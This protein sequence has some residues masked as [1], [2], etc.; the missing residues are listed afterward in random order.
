MTDAPPSRAPDGELVRHLT[1]LFEGLEA[2]VLSELGGEIEWRNLRG[3]ETLFRRGDPG[4]AAYVVISGRLRAVIEAES[5]ERVLNEMGAGET[6]GEMALLAADARSATVYAVRDAQLA[7][8]SREAFERLTA[9]HPAALRRIAGFVVERL[10]RRSEP[11]GPPRVASVTLTLVAARPEVDLPAFAEAL[12]E[13]LGRIGRVQHLRRRDVDAGLGRAGAADA[14]DPDSLAVRLVQWLNARE[15]ASDFVLYEADREWSAWSERAVRQADHVLVVAR[16]EDGPELGPGEARLFRDPRRASERSLV[17]LHPPG[18]RPRGTA[19]WLAERP[20]TH[21]FHVR[22]DV[23]GDRARLARIVTGRAVG[24]VLGGGGARGFA[25]LGVLRAFEEAGIPIDLV[26]GTSIGSVIGALPALGHGAEESLAICRRHIS[27]LFDP[28]L[29]V[30]SLL[31]GRRI[32]SRLASALGPLDIEDLLIPY[33]CVATNLSRA[34]QSI[35]QRGSLLRAVRASISLPGVLPP[36]S[37]DGDLLVDG[38]LLNNLPVDVMQRISRGGP[39]VAVDVSPKEDLRFAHD[40]ADGISGWKVLWRA[41]NPFVRRLDVPYISSVLMR[42][43]LVSSTASERQHRAATSTSLYLSMPVS[44]WSLL[45]FDRIVPI[46]DRGY[47]ASVDPIRSWWSSQTTST[48][49]AL[50]R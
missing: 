25:H 3:G 42:S 39:I 37:Q 16:A 27:S 35:H 26:G 38:S 21:H 45:E 19:A 6:V 14:P 18:S 47:A 11:L 44:E 7:R 24:L 10:R 30:V 34:E 20:V 15:A 17:L 50:G 48:S 31:A 36:V 1:R 9:R 46:A 8:I 12:A 33:F 43:A 40:L 23:A 49:L 32:G 5:G 41:L 13:Q 28:T 29:P 2:E 4:D 22:R